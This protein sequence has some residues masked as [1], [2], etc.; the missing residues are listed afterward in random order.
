M[1]APPRQASGER[2]AASLQEGPLGRVLGAGDGRLVGLHRLP[3]LVPSRFLGEPNLA[4]H[5]RLNA[6]DAN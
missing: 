3:M 1:C 4:A 6:N 5:I 2:L